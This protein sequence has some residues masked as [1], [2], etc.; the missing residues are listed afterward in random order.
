MQT[1]ASKVRRS[2]AAFVHEV[3]ETDAPKR[4][5]ERSQVDAHRSSARPA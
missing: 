3:L 1:D 5:H 4:I 2:R